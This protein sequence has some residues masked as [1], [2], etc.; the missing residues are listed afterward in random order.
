MK[1]PRNQA[2]F[3]KIRF[4]HL[5]A[6]AEPR[7]Q[8]KL[9]QRNTPPKTKTQ[10][11]TFANQTEPITPETGDALMKISAALLL[12]FSS[13]TLALRAESDVRLLPDGIEVSCAPQLDQPHELFSKQPG[14]FHRPGLPRERHPVKIH[15]PWPPTPEADALLAP[16]TAMKRA[17]PLKSPIQS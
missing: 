7:I 6:E 2:E 12:L 14:Y 15:P 13:L 3:T 10:L 8:R 4:T 5:P 9:T 1:W 16:L 17:S 11:P